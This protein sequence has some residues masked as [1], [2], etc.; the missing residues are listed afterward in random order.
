LGLSVKVQYPTIDLKRT[1]EEIHR[2]MSEYVIESL[3]TWVIATTDVVP[4][5]TG[6]S[7]ASFTKL[8]TEASYNLSITPKG[9][10]NNISLGVESFS[11]GVFADESAGSYGW[12]WSSDL[13]YIHVVD[14]HNRF[15]DAGQFVVEQL[16]PPVFPPPS[17]E[18]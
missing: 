13:D 8:A 17:I 7:K 3:R 10:K 6:A 14:R 9:K 2:V 5:L 15:L 18:T 12:T 4:V 16:P 1:R 11:G